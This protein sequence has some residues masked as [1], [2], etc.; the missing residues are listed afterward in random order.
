MSEILETATISDVLRIIKWA[1]PTDRDLMR[2]PL[3]RHA[4]PNPSFRVIDDRKWRCYSN[5]QTGGNVADLMIALDL[6]KTNVEA[7]A[8][9]ERNLVVP[10]SAPSP[11]PAAPKRK[12]GAIG[13]RDG[14]ALN[15]RRVYA[16]SCASI[17]PVETK[18]LIHPYLPRGEATWFEGA[19]KTG[20][21]TIALDIVARISTGTP[22]VDGSP[23]A[24]GRA[25]I[26]TCED[27]DART[28]VPRLIAAGA[29]LESVH[30][31]KVADAQ[32]NELMPSFPKRSSWHRGRASSTIRGCVAG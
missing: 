7:A 10:A 28:I 30:V 5:C 26:L 4:D 2:C 21:T 22:W 19:T 29:A 6:A 25:A 8:L 9:L 24:K 31:I 3:P 20:K 18:Y 12:S 27:D 23:I 1:F 17:D 16:L 11:T 15:T 32:D 13:A 14:D